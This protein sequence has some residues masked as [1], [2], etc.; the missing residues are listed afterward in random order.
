MKSVL[1]QL[2]DGEIAPMEQFRPTLNEYRRMWEESL[3]NDKSFL[4]KLDEPMRKEFETLM[5]EHF[6][7][8]PI[9][10]AQVYTDGFKL[11]VRM[12][13]ESFYEYN[14]EGN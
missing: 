9:E 3:E 2:Y 10:M 14:D 7:L 12:M 6:N 13:C 8:I 5:E 11:G 4:K 1:K